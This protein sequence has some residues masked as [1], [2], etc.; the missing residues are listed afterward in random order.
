MNQPVEKWNVLK[1]MFLFFC[2]NWKWGC[3]E[4]NP[5]EFRLIKQ[6]SLNATGLPPKKNLG[7]DQS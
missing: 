6:G 3:S 7:E 2:W 5:F 1:M 4:M